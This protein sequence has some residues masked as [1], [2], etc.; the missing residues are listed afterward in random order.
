MWGG[1]FTGILLPTVMFPHSILPSS[2]YFT[3]CLLSHL[4]P[5]PNIFI[6]F[7]I[8]NPSVSSHFILWDRLQA[9]DLHSRLGS[10]IASK[11]RSE[12]GINQLCGRSTPE[13][14]HQLG[15]FLFHSP[16]R[17]ENGLCYLFQECWEWA[18]TFSA[19][20]WNQVLRESP[21]FFSPSGHFL[22]PN[23]FFC[24]RLELEDCIK[25]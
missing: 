6:L 21:E 14:S 23:L 5:Y 1:T 15:L 17:R 25:P 18:W 22:T 16:W 24:K 11:C 12:E 7:L 10:F 9:V 8:P 2:V 19:V 13:E 20:V 3:T 4:L